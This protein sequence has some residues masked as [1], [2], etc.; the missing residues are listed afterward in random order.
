[1]SNPAWRSLGASLNAASLLLF[2]LTMI[3]SAIA[4]R[5]HYRARLVPLAG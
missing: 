1:M 2:A 3:G 4:W 5:V